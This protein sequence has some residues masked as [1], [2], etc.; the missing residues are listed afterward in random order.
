MSMTSPCMFPAARSRIARF[1]LHRPKSVGE[2]CA[3]LERH[4]D[5][6]LIHAGGLN[7]VGLMKEGLDIGA[8]VHIAGIDELREIAVTDE[9]LRIGSAV[10]HQEIATSPLVQEV[11]PFVANYFE[12][13]GNIRIRIQGTIGGNILADQPMYEVLPLLFVA[14]AML[15]FIDSAGQRTKVAPEMAMQERRPQKL[16]TAIFIPLRP[17]HLAWSRELRPYMSVVV[18]RSRSEAARVALMG[19]PSGFSGFR[20][21]QEDADTAVERWLFGV[22]PPPMGDAT[23][24]RHAS[25][26][27]LKRCL[28]KALEG[29]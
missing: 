9:G 6:V 4:G 25:R 7:V 11:M 20:V 24:F 2:V 21:P 5:E 8:L 19:Q 28:A 16:L 10:T 29:P 18:S 22:E 1:V 17:L 3:L 12:G 15:E 27:L 13:I 14:D 26:V 23:Y